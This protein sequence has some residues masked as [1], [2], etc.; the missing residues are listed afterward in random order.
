MKTVFIE[1]PPF[2]QLKDE[3]S[4]LKQMIKN[5]LEA[6]IRA[7]YDFL[8]SELARMLKGPIDGVIISSVEIPAVDQHLCLSATAWNSA[9]SQTRSPAEMVRIDRCCLNPGHPLFLACS[10][11]SLFRNT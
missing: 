1:L 11:T 10:D 3:M 8:P 7:C 5:E 2:E 6:E 4:D 9:L